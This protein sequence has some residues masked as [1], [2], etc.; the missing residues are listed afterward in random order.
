MSSVFTKK[1]DFSL[2]A[3]IFK[4]VRKV[5]DWGEDVIELRIQSLRR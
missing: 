3:L 5:K 1:E 2:T 4:E